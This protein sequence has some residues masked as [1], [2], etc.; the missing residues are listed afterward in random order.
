M[1]KITFKT[2]VNF[3]RSDSGESFNQVMDGK[4]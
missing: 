3:D 4:S 2:M 1:T